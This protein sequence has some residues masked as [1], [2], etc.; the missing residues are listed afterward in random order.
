VKFL[1]VI[2]V[3][4]NLLASCV[5]NTPVTPPNAALPP[6]YR[7]VDTPASDL[8]DTPWQQLYTDPVLQK[9]IATALEH[10]LNVA[11]AYQTILQAQA[12]VDINRGKQQPQVNGEVKAPFNRSA[13]ETPLTVIV[14]NNG[15]AAHT[16]FQ[17][18]LGLGISYEVDFFGRLASATAAA[19]AQLLASVEGRNAVLW[20]LVANVA[21]NYFT[22]R[23]QDDE[24]DI[25]QRT[26]VARKLNLDLVKARY[27]GGVADLQAVRQAEES[28]Y[29]VSTS[30]PAFQ[31]DIALTENTL[32]ILIGSYPQDIPRGL[33]LE[34]QITMPL[35][36]PAG[37]PSTLLTRRPDIMQA[38]ANLAAASAN[39]DV[40]RKLL[41]PQLTF[42]ITAGAGY[43]AINS[44]FYGPEGL[45]SL[46]P[47][48]IAPIFNGG[49]LKANV[50]LTQAEREQVAVSYLQSVQSAMQEVANAVVSYNRLREFSVQSDLQ[51]A[52]AVDSTRLAVLR[53][54]GGVTSYLEVL[55]SETRSYQD[56]LTSV[57]AHLNER[58]ALVQLYLALGGGWQQA[59]S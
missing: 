31:R 23:E 24:L 28:Y 47:Q 22:L 40:A 29:E 58:V 13:G 41:Y 44:T 8:A 9:L 20:Q 39:L 27:I 19:R 42:G 33:P 18:Q 38:E 17:P 2:G 3:L 16:T 49:S 54:Q 45:I 56:E 12:N 5:P 48:L 55:D 35:L 43:T 4:I 52:A 37:V 57:Q 51:T 11:S 32:S 14:G 34:K 6:S 26:L 25:A 7:G 30:I 46:V 21:T 1:I 36:P 53:Y 59:G 50:R 10:N 15:Q